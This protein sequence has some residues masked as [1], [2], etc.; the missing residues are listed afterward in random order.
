[1]DKAF[2]P[3][4]AAPISSDLFVWAKGEGVAYESDLPRNYSGRLYRDSCDAGF[5]VKSSITGKMKTFI[6]TE[7]LH[8]PDD[9]VVGEVFETSDGIKIKVFFT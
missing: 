2:R 3:A 5:T 6:A 9:E 1:M 4:H 8:A 7:W